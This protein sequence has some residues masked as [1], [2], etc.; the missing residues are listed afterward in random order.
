MTSQAETGNDAC[1]FPLVLLHLL[2]WHK[3]FSNLDDKRHMEQRPIVSWPPEIGEPVRIGRGTQPTTPDFWA[4]NTY[5]CISWRF[6]GCLWWSIFMAIDWSTHLRHC[7]KKLIVFT[8]CTAWLIPDAAQWSENF[9][10]D[11]LISQ[12]LDFLIYEKQTNKKTLNRISFMVTSTF[13]LMDWL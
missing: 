11:R 7:S 6:C 3:K 1:T 2:H 13:Y 10:E 4:V 12:I 9:G 8:T 5:C